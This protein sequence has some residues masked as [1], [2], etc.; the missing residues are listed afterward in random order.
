MGRY[1]TRT[2]PETPAE[3]RRTLRDWTAFAALMLAVS[4]VAELYPIEPSDDVA[5]P[6]VALSAL[7]PVLPAVPASGGASQGETGPTASPAGGGQAAADQGPSAAATSDVLE[8]EPPPPLA[9][10]TVGSEPCTASFY[11]AGE[12][13][14]EHT[15]SGDRF[16]PSAMTVAS[17]KLPM[18]TV[19]E[20][21]PV[22]S[23][24][25]VTLEVNDY[26]PHPRLHR[27]LDLTAGAWDALGLARSLGL[28]D[29]TYR[30]VGR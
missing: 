28:V 7:S 9:P 12:P 30:V 26:G 2:G 27:C 20:V 13:L 25:V 16:D 8:P 23:P 10:A 6:T 18:G 14:N 19:I 5:A 3:V 11:G 1:T 21:S 22:G 24:Q 15:Y 29:V 17:P 4:V